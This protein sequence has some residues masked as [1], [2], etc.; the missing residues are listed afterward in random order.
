MKG[1]GEVP[2]YFADFAFGD[3]PM[4]APDRLGP[5]YCCICEAIAPYV[6]WP[7]GLRAHLRAPVAYC[8]AHAGMVAWMVTQRIDR[9]VELSDA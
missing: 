7:P 4:E 5:F 8:S 6:F 1:T 9:A 2:A 3:F